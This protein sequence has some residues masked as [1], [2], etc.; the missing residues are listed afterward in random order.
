MCSGR[1]PHPPRDWC[2]FRKLSSLLRHAKYSARSH[3]AICAGASVGASSLNWAL[4]GCS[5]TYKCKSRTGKRRQQAGQRAGQVM[6]DRKFG[7]FASRGLQSL[8]TLL[9]RINAHALLQFRSRWAAGDCWV[10]QV[11]TLRSSA[12]GR[13]AL[14]SFQASKAICRDM[15][16]SS[17]RP[18]HPHPQALPCPL[19][20]GQTAAACICQLFYRRWHLFHFINPAC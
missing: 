12:P 1:L 18:E 17:L 13:T 10:A 6:F 9:A 19:P 11:R 14:A 16:V 15:H 3:G 5:I 7:S 8:V 2:M 20:P 4:A